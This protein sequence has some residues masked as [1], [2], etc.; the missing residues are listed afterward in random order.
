MHNILL[1]RLGVISANRARIRFTGICCA[2]ELTISGDSIFAFQHLNHDRPG[3]HIAHEVGEKRPL[4]VNFVEL[5][6]LILA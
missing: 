1:D 3:C 2:H 6:R 5:L 4:P